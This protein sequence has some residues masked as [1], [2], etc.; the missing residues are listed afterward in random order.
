MQRLSTF[1][2]ICACVVC[3]RALAQIIF[4]QSQ[5]QKQTNMR[6]IKDERETGRQPNSQGAK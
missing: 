5:T 1:V 6:Q 4:K 3:V 2:F